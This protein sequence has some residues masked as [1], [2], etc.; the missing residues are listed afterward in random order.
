[1]K[2]RLAVL[3]VAVLIAWGLKR[4][5]A[6]ARADDLAWILSPTARVVGVMAGTTF[7]PEPGE[8]YLSRDRM[9]VI[10]KACAGI[11]FMIAAFAMLMVAL[12]HRIRSPLSGACVLVVSLVASYSTAVLVNAGRIGLAMWLA[13]HPVAVA[14]L[15]AAEMHRLEG[16]VVYFGGLVLLYEVVQRLEGRTLWVGWRLP[17]AVYYTVALAV[18]LANGASRSGGF[19]A[20]ALVVLLVPPVLIVLGRGV[21]AAVHALAIRVQYRGPLRPASAIETPRLSVGWGTIYPLSRRAY[22][23]PE[24]WRP[25]R[26]RPVR[27][28]H[29]EP[30]E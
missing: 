4:H 5:Y 21:C 16:V 3:A 23:C 2:L 11:N 9:F 1:M 8:G 30:R 19:L 7:A 12:R 20:H 10:E 26:P 28:R 6:D 27:R 14:R 17:L 25:R 24:H 18:P 29:R 15:S 22:V 13:T